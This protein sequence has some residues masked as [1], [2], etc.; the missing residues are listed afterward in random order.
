M[1]RWRRS[2]ALPR[3]VSPEAGV[4]L[5]PA[6]LLSGDAAQAAVEA[7]TGRWLAGGRFA[8][9]ACEVLLRDSGVVTAT[10]APV[11]AVARWA[12][13][14]AG[15][16]LKRLSAP[17]PPVLGIAMDCPAIM[18]VINVTPDSFSD[19]GDY[20]DPA[21][22]IAHG[23]ALAA[24]G[25]AILDVG[26]ES[27]RPGSDPVDAAA[28]LGRVLPV[29][30]G[31]AGVGP[32]VSIDSRR[33]TVIAAALDAG[34]ALVN[35]VSALTHD[36]ESIAVVAAAR[37][38]VVLM[39]SLGDPK[40]MQTDPAY[41]CAPLD[42]YDTLEARIQACRAAGIERARIVVDPGI[43]FGKSPPSSESHLGHNIEILQRLGLFH[44][45][46]CALLLGVSR[47]SFIGRLAGVDAPKDRV[48]G[49]LAAGLAALDQ[50]VQLLRVHDVA[51]TKQA[52]AVWDALTAG[53]IVRGA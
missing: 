22:A 19:G 33:A 16:I 20:A 41:D 40:T 42:V 45:L 50:G 43:G 51:E 35:D 10:I 32:P 6:A 44:G 34:A 8:F 46:G 15:A 39:H 3:S 7:G 53:M 26:G 31:L 38:P 36:P 52:I 48:P 17:R 21:T 1:T 4:Y 47:K 14:R 28:E 24:A 12:T 23:H 18:G 13:G 2:P 30:R 5:R 9:T 49:S 27:T 25:A 11:G 29:V 37:A